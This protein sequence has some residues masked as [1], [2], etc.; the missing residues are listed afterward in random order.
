MIDLNDYGSM[1]ELVKA[2]IT[3][4]S[5]FADSSEK[6]VDAKLVDLVRRLVGGL[7]QVALTDEKDIDD[8]FDDRVLKAVHS[9]NYVKTKDIMEQMNLPYQNALAGKRVEEALKRLTKRGDLEYYRVS[10]DVWIETLG[11]RPTNKAP[12]LKKWTDPWPK[13]AKC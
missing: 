5:D 11:V 10:G 4:L 8:D 6:D 12:K 2:L 1:K 13:R 9:L 7:C 3:E